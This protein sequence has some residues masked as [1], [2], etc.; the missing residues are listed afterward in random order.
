MNILGIAY[1]TMVM[2]LPDGSYQFAYEQFN[3]DSI[4][5]NALSSCLR[6]GE[7]F[8]KEDPD[9][10]ITFDCEFVPEERSF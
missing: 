7:E 9:R 2:V 8:I 10:N 3:S 1:L 4:T 5:V 6:A